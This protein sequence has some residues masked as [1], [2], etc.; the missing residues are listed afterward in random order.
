MGRHAVC[1]DG[2]GNG[3]NQGAEHRG[4]DQRQGD[5]AQDL[6]LV[7]ALDLTHLLQLGVDGAE[8]AGHLDVGEGVVVHGHAEHNGNRAIGQHVGNGNAQAGQKAVGAAGGGPEH[9][10]P[11]QGLGPGGDHV[12]HGDQNAQELLA[13]DVGADHQPG[14][15]RAQRHGDQRGEKAADEGVQQRLPQHSLGHVADGH[16]PPVVHGEFASLVARH[17]AQLA[18]RQGKGGLDHGQQGD[19]D[20]AEQHNEADQHDHVEGV[21]QNVQDQIFQPCFRQGFSGKIFLCHGNTS[22]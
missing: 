15:H 1:T 20:Q 18:L 10:Q 12:G 6:G 19:H 21:A 9:R 2:L 11:G 3:H 16:V 8:R 22:F 4:Q 7:G 14:Q 13:G 5:V 17:T